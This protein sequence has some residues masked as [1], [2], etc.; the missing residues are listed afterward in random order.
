MR[1]EIVKLCDSG[2]SIKVGVKLFWGIILDI[3]DLE[4]CE[5]GFK[6]K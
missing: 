1:G 6:W 2:F 4:V 5:I 3:V